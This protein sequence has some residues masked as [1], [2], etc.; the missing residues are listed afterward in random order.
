MNTQHVGKLRLEK[1]DLTTSRHFVRTAVISQM[2]RG[3]MN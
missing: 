3:S 1:I 2:G